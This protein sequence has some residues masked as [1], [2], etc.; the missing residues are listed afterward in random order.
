MS[1]APSRPVA[2][3]ARLAFPDALRGLALLGIFPVNLP[4]FALPLVWMTELAPMTGGAFETACGVLTQ[5]LFEQKFITLFSLLFGVGLGLQL[6]R[7]RGVGWDAFA[8][9][10]LGVLFGFGLLHALLLFWGDVLG[11]YA[12]IGLCCAWAVH[13]SDTTRLAL[14][15]VLIA[16]PGYALFLALPLGFAV[17]ALTAIAPPTDPIPYQ[18]GLASGTGL[19]FLQGMVA[20]GPEFETELNRD[21]PLARVAALRLTIW[22]F[23]LASLPWWYG[24]RIAGLFLVGLTVAADGRLLRPAEHPDLFRRLLRGGLLVGAP[25]TLAQLPLVFLPRGTGALVLDE[26]LVYF[27]SLGL[28]AAIAGGLGLALPRLPGLA[29][30]PL[31]SLGRMALSGYLLQSVLA[32]ALFAGWG[33]AAFGSLHRGQLWGVVLAV[34]VV[35]LALATAWLRVFRQGPA[36]ALW[37]ALTYRRAR[38]VTG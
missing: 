6:A 36:E 24:L 11:S 21:A 1:D 4:V 14:A 30:T 16:L 22:S 31:V 12:L 8:L 3:D 18:A 29:L 17:D 13:A 23:A 5:L 7:G 28:A 2:P 32:S 10:R 19:E 25:L 34:W 38:S 35:E 15:A 27:G 26:L 20:W 33:L 37:R 9:R